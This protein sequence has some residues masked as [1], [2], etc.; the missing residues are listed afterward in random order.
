MKEFSAYAAFGL[1]VSMGVLFG[2]F[3]YLAVTQ[4]ARQQTQ[5]M[6]QWVQ[7]LPIFG[8]EVFIVVWGVFQLLLALCLLLGVYTQKASYLSAFAMM[9]IAINLGF[10][11]LAYR[12]IAIAFG[13]LL[14]ST[15]DEYIWSLR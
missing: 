2:V 10:T 15:Q 12:D 11:E 3:G 13:A 4:P 5:W 14:L 9:A 1:R 6:A 8:S 7:E